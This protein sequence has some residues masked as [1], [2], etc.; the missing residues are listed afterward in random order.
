M[1]IVNELLENIVMWAILVFESIGVIVILIS[2]IQGIVHYI[3]RDAGTRLVL[4]H[5]MS[6]GLEFKIGSE[7]LRTVLVREW[8]E[9][10]IVAGIIILRAA[11]TFLIQW[12][13]KVEQRDGI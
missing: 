6:L 1:E 13:I 12:E 10:G 8:F 9:I 5:G 11:L 4:A 7:I 2:G 3:K